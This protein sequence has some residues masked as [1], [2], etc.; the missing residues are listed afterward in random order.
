MQ[1]NDKEIH[2]TIIIL[3]RHCLAK[4]KDYN[5]IEHDELIEC[6]EL[7][8]SKWDELPDNTKSII[9]ECI[10]EAIESQKNQRDI[11]DDNNWGYDTLKTWMWLCYSTRIYQPSRLWML[12]RLVTHPEELESAKQNMHLT[13]SK[14]YK[15][16]NAKTDSTTND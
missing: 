10:H 7:I 13:D 6:T 14:Y 3:V 16:S 2:L 5:E 1:L 4:S 12:N 8:E 9:A 15:K 11:N